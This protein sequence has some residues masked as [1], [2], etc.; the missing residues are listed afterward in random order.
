MIR[1]FAHQSARCKLKNQAIGVSRGG[2]NTEI[3]VL[4]NE[5][6]QVLK[7][8]LTGGQIHYSKLTLDLFSAINLD[9]KTILASKAYSY[10]KIRDYFEQQGDATCI[11]DK[12]N[13][14]HAFDADL[15]T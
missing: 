9:G 2:K 6:M 14:K 13:F 12:E 5:R 4:I 8:V 3:H 1:P 15:T 10:D 11:P 7:V